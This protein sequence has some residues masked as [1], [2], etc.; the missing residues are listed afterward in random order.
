MAV[1]VLNMKYLSNCLS[2]DPDLNYPSIDSPKTGQLPD[3]ESLL[4]I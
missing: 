1:W 4:Y 3:D 2:I